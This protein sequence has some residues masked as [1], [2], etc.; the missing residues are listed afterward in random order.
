M[1]GPFVWGGELSCK[2]PCTSM[3]KRGGTNSESGNVRGSH[4]ED[5]RSFGSLNAKKGSKEDDI[6][7]RVREGK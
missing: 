3:G 5:E 1:T 7:Q 4:A 6:T 2:L